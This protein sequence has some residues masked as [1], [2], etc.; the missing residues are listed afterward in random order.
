MRVESVE[1]HILTRA[2]RGLRGAGI[3]LKRFWIRV[4]KSRRFFDLNGA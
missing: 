3:F 2:Y 1:Q 4:S